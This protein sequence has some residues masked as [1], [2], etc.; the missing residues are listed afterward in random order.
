MRAKDANG[1]WSDY[2][3]SGT[4]TVKNNTAPGAPESITVP[5]TVYGGKETEI[6]RAVHRAPLTRNS[7]EI[8]F[9]VSELTE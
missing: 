5:E 8:W 3:T 2:K 7:R 9:P 4:Y 1:Y 6:S